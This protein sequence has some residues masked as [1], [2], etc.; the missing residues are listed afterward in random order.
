MGDDA[1][2]RQPNA[3]AIPELA[4]LLGFQVGNPAV[5]QGDADGDQ[6]KQIL[7]D[8][9]ADVDER[10]GRTW[11]LRAK[12]FVDVAKHRHDFD[13]E[14]NGDAD[15]DDGDGGRIHHGRLDLL[16]QLGSALQVGGQ[17][18]QNFRQQTAA[19][20]GRDH[21]DVQLVKGLGVL[22]QRFRKTVTALDAG[23]NVL[24]GIAHDFVGRLLGQRLEG[25][26]HRQTGVNHR[27]Q[28]AGEH[29][30]IGQ[31]DSAAGGFALPADLFLDRHDQQVPVEQCRDGS[32]LVLGFQIAADFFTRS[33][34]PRYISKGGHS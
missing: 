34:F 11:Q 16:A 7:L 5:N 22:L 2:D 17:A 25:L 23:A 20:A 31:S 28:L 33:G 29:D 3:G 9:V 24:D 32:L 19:F 26:D 8:E 12:P 30:Q 4:S 21:A 13:Q 14:E 10:L 6:V 18:G 15:G 27:R 1:E